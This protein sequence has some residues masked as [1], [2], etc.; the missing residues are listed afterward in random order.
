LGIVITWNPPSPSFITALFA[1]ERFI[2]AGAITF[3]LKLGESA[4]VSTSCVLE[5]PSRRERERERERERVKRR[6]K[7]GDRVERIEYTRFV[8]CRQ[9][10]LDCWINVTCILDALS[11]AANLLHNIHDLGQLRFCVMDP[12]FVVDSACPCKDQPCW[13]TFTV[14]ATGVQL[15]MDP[16]IA[17]PR[18]V[19]SKLLK[20]SEWDVGRVPTVWAEHNHVV[21]DCHSCE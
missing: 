17:S 3:H 9:F 14:T 1:S 6:M 8:H 5:R 12:R 20:H 21:D 10:R 16:A 4:H 15:T 18:V 13:L 11:R 19:C 2:S 7:V